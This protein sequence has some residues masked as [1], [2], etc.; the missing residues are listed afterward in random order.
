MCACT[1]VLWVTNPFAAVLAVPALH[2]WIWA[3]APDLHLRRPIAVLLMIVG[4]VL[5]YVI[6][7]IESRVVHK[8]ETSK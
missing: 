5:Y 7:I 1:L 3:V 4:F 2:A 6:D 8:L